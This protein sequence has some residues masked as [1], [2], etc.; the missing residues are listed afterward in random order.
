VLKAAMI[1]M[2]FSGEE[3]IVRQV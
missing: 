1:T 2:C 3:V